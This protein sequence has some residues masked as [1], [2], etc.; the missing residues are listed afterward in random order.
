M[1]KTCHRRG[2]HAIGGMAAFVPNRR[3]QIVTEK[4][5]AAVSADKARE[6]GAGCDGTWVAH[7]DLVAVARQE[8]EI[9]LGDRPN[10]VKRQRFDVEVA[11]EDLLNL[12]FPGEVTMDGLRTNV[13]VG[14]QYLTAWL[15]GTGAA[16]INNLMEDVATA[17]ISRSQI[18]Q[19][20]RHSVSAADGTPVTEALVRSI[21]GETVRQL[22][23]ERHPNLETL[24]TARKIFE[25][26]AL[27]EDFVEFLTLSAYELIN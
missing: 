26:V 21:A 27:G 16:S 2:A 25:E 20:V 1:V 17:E 4:A 24:H 12:D 7:P 22:E 3:D 19:W 9:V 11:A 14:L 23:E 13:S 6:A 18:W 10:Q 5:I 8:F 15:S